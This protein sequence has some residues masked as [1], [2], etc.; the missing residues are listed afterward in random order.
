MLLGVPKIKV[1]PPPQKSGHF[2]IR[3]KYEKIQGPCTCIVSTSLG[4]TLCVC[5]CIYIYKQRD[6]DIDLKKI[7]ISIFIVVYGER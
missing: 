6:L 3:R 4:H 1:G 7:Q 5:L 2:E